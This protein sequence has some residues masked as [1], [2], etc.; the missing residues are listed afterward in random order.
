LQERIETLM[1]HEVQ[2]NRAL[3]PDLLE[4]IEVLSG[5]LDITLS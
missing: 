3:L 5:K 2:I 4:Q 1:Q